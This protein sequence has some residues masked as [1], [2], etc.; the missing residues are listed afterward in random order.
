MLEAVDYEAKHRKLQKLRLAGTGD[1]LF[2]QSTYVEWETSGSSANLC[3]RGIRMLRLG[4]YHDAMLTLSQLAAVK[5]SLR[6]RSD[7]REAY[8]Y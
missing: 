5:A 4:L 2:Q 1:W 7:I 8:V 6:T 3:C